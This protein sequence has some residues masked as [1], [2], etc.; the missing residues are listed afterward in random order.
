MLTFLNVVV[1]VVVVVTEMCVFLGLCSGVY[2]GSIF[3][4]CDA[5]SLHNRIPTFRGTQSSHFQGL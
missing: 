4:G 5:T 3:I 2:E 1:V